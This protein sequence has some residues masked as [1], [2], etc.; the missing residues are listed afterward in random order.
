MANLSAG[1]YLN[2]SGSVAAV[3][4]VSKNPCSLVGIFVSSNTGA[5]TIAVFDDGGTGTSVTMVSAFTP[6]ISVCWY[7]APMQA[8]NGLCVS[9]SAATLTFTVA[10]D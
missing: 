4:N 3:S 9:V 7:P 8:R 10:F 1:N 6:N 2:L 5:G